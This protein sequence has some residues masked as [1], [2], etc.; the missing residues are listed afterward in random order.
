MNA[1]KEFESANP[2]LVVQ[3]VDWIQCRY[4]FVQCGKAARRDT[5]NGSP[6]S[7]NYEL[8]SIGKLAIPP[9]TASPKLGSTPRLAI[10]H[11]ISYIQQDPAMQ[12]YGPENTVLKI[13]RSAF[14]ASRV[15]RLQGDP[16]GTPSKR[17]KNKSPR[18]LSNQDKPDIL[19]DESDIEDITFLLSDCE[20][21]SSPAVTA[22][23]KSRKANSP[24]L[25][26]FVPGS[27]DKSTIRLL[28]PPSHAMPQA[29][30]RLHKDL[31]ELLKVQGSTPLHEL[32]WYID[33]DITNM[34]QWILEL[35]SF[36]ATLPL[37]IDMKAAGLTSIVL[38]LRFGLEYPMSPPFV[39]VIRP[40]FLPYHMGGGGHVTAGGA[41]CM[42]LL[43][44]SG[45]SAVS[46]IES[47][48]LQVRM[49]MCSLEPKPARLE[50]TVRGKQSDYG[51]AE[52]VDAYERACRAHGWKPSNVRGLG[53]EGALGEASQRGLGRA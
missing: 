9:K 39:R 43:T 19:S 31:K 21:D 2:H 28:A 33:G 23:G 5:E 48:L 17:Q 14:P 4:L 42:E 10:P 47:V 24:P 29:A 27:L 37:A 46:S 11:E 41:M 52:A 35:H 22:K 32:G 38:E 3:H 20:S 34:F 7:K 26:D 15:F 36:E 51:V 44:N 1:P 50:S 30:N 45:W 25:T 13:P 8:P 6:A 40:R 53:G 49:A 12:V 18:R 16:K